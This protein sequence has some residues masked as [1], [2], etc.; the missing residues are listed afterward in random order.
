M[1]GQDTQ[2][3]PVFR[4]QI[5]I[6]FGAGLE[7]FLYRCPVLCTRRSPHTS[8]LRLKAT[9]AVQMWSCWILDLHRLHGCT[10]SA[11]SK[12]WPSLPPLSW[13]LLIWTGGE[14]CRV[15]GEQG[16]THESS[17]PVVW[18]FKH[19]GWAGSR[20]GFPLN[21]DATQLDS[22]PIAGVVC[23]PDKTPV[24]GCWRQPSKSDGPERSAQW[25]VWNLDSVGNE[26]KVGR[27]QECCDRKGWSGSGES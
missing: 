11:H 7:F 16:Q 5:F 26:N 22:Q 2:R 18:P 1:P 25:Q 19:V 4:L 14:S 17:T 21:A 27:S 20:K 3:S 6:E 10:W 24:H 15:E 13:P 12:W 8:C 23:W 9:V